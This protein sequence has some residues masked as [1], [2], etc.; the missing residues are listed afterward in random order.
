[1]KWRIQPLSLRDKLFCEYTGSRTDTL[2]FTEEDLPQKELI[3][4]IKTQLGETRAE[5]EEDGLRPFC[6]ANPAPAVSRLSCINLCSC[7]FF[8][9]PLYLLL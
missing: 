3:R 6:I 2:R 8:L 1:M 7:M 4:V 9:L 5:I